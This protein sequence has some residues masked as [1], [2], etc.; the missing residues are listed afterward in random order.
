MTTLEQCE[1]NNNRVVFPGERVGQ[2][3]QI[4]ILSCRQDSCSAD[5]YTTSV[6]TLS[7]SSATIDNSS[8]WYL[9]ECPSTIATTYSS[10]NMNQPAIVSASYFIASIS[11]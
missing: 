5:G 10:A 4:S 2:V 9:E 3:F 6:Y 11:W 8:P 1:S 7:V